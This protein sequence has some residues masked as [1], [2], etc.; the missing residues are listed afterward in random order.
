MLSRSGMQAV[1]GLGVAIA[2][3]LTAL[4]PRDAVW[5][6]AVATAPEIETQ[7]EGNASANAYREKWLKATPEQQEWLKATPEKGATIAEQIGEDGARQYAKEHGYTPIFDGK[8]RSVRQGPDQVY[9]DPRTDETVVIEAKGGTSPLGKGYGYKQ[10]T[11]SWAVKSA[12]QILHNPNASPAERDA[13]KRIVEAAW[14]GKLRVEVVRTPH[15]LGLPGTPVVE[16]LETAVDDIDEAARLAEETSKRF[17]IPL[18]ETPKPS[19]LPSKGDKLGAA[20]MGLESAS[21]AR[22]KPTLQARP[23]GKAASAAER[24]AAQGGARGTSRAMSS[25]PAQAASGSISTLSKVAKVAGAVAVVGV[26]AAARVQRADQVERAYAR[27]EISE[28][29]RRLEHAKNV[30]GCVGGWAGAWAGAE[31]GG[32]AGAAIG[33]AICP[34]IGTGIGG[35][36]GSIAG[37]VGGYF[38]GEKMA[39]AGTEALLGK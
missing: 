3:G 2:A 22:E 9:F 10:G 4:R 12:E 28:H 24:G 11:K 19:K 8:G 21:L 32:G 26:D 27:G 29:Q 17:G 31:A 36:V 7:T 18:I 1:V 25:A 33:T 6:Q 20:G 30:T 15:T 13:A 37:A 34:G 23:A 35:V 39:E 16:R 38:A 14:N 5:A